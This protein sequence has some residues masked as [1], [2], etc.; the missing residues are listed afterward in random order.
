M[1][2]ADLDCEPAQW[3]YS[4]A[5]RPYADATLTGG[6]A[7]F[8][9]E[10]T[11]WSI[12]RLS[13]STVGL[14]FIGWVNMTAHP[15]F[16]PTDVSR[17][18]GWLQNSDL[19]NTT[20]SDNGNGETDDC[21]LV[22]FG[23]SSKYDPPDQPKLNGSVPSVQTLS[24]GSR[25]PAVTAHW[26]NEKRQVA[27]G[28]NGQPLTSEWV[29]VTNMTAL[30]CKPSLSITKSLVTLPKNAATTSQGFE[31]TQVVDSIP[32][33]SVSLSPF[34]LGMRVQAISNTQSMIGYG[35]RALYFIGL[36][37]MMSPYEDITH[38]FDPAVLMNSTRQVYQRISAQYLKTHLTTPTTG[39]VPADM[40]LIGARLVVDKLTL[41]IMDAVLGVFASCALAMCFLPN[42]PR[43]PRRFTS[44][45]SI[46]LLLRN[47][48]G[49]ERLCYGTSTSRLSDMKEWLR[50]YT[51]Y[52]QYYQCADED[53]FRVVPEL[54]SAL[55]D[56]DQEPELKQ[57]V[58][59]WQ[60]AVFGKGL[61]L[62]TILGPL[63]LTAGLEASRWYSQRHD[64]LGV[65]PVKGEKK[66]AWQFGPALVM[67]T[68]T[69]LFGSLDFSTRS[70]WPY[71]T[72]SSRKGVRFVE[73]FETPLD[74]FAAQSV[75]KSAYRHQ[76]GLL[77]TSL[78]VCVSPLLTI[79]V[80]G[81]FQAQS[82]AVIRNA[83]MQLSGT[84]M[85]QSDQRIFTGYDSSSTIAAMILYNNISWPR[86]TY[87]NLIL[88][89]F[90]VVHNDSQVGSLL[91]QAS[92]PAIKINSKCTTVDI[93]DIAW[94][95]N[96]M[97]NPV[98]SPERLDV[99]LT[100]S[101][102]CT[103]AFN[104]YL[105]NHDLTSLQYFSISSMPFSV[106]N[107]TN[108]G[109]HIGLSVNSNTSWPEAGVVPYIAS[110]SAVNLACNGTTDGVPPLQYIF[111]QFEQSRPT[112]LAMV[113]C[114]PQAD[115]LMSNITFETPTYNIQ[116]MQAIPGTERLFTAD[117]TMF[118][119]PGYACS[120]KRDDVGNETC[121]QQAFMTSI[122]AIPEDEIFGSANAKS[123][124]EGVG[125]ILDTVFAQRFSSLYR[126]SLN[127]TSNQ[128]LLLGPGALSNATVLGQTQFRVIQSPISTV[129]LQ[130]L[131]SFLALCA[132]TAW[133]CTK[134]KEIL[135]KNPT[136]I[137]AM[138]SLLAGAR[139][140][141]DDYI[142]A[143]AEML[144]DK[145]LREQGVLQ[146]K[147]V[148][149]GWWGEGTQRRYGIDVV[150]EEEQPGPTAAL[151]RDEPKISASPEASESAVP[152]RFELAGPEISEL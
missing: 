108:D 115:L 119:E 135:P 94:G 127:D 80:S 149:L 81:L 120:D 148:R 73:L 139:L 101:T 88:P 23:V 104:Q 33:S 42:F 142:P 75:W 53:L 21:F 69:I 30:I 35:G 90:T 24:A 20:C 143:G 37:D 128:A 15:N 91:Y 5:T 28:S 78:A 125:Q 130:C 112:N 124:A 8:N 152:G 100:T 10:S 59:W 117:R 4:N 113:Q 18:A 107:I 133:I 9:F 46:A 76:W 61:R 132:L 65:A 13:L 31:V 2:S 19:M 56:T 72:L 6:L 138:A 121:T 129:I 44:I 62:V 27:F 17:K 39:T 96:D 16:L 106:M 36:C 25:D 140:L 134:S 147:R 70:I 150:E 11:R 137:A 82:T 52:S 103:A 64:G 32:S 58:Q 111:V 49:F 105:D 45:G 83:P 55:G 12:N 102:Q 145:K 118:S 131:L 126:T 51:F 60:P 1:A 26:A 110:P 141:R 66:Y 22:T 77:A 84:F 47:S 67:T 40:T 87:Q 63:I 114:T 79:I 99:N 86:Y 74:N 7:D 89:E 151:L 48:T 146:G 41:R 109:M 123:L 97:P 68:V 95:M 43:M 92:V 57:R 38:F 3:S 116:D 29:K 93:G 50:G 136:T 144:S 71:H 54:G 98:K 34:E 122:Y 85:G 14:D